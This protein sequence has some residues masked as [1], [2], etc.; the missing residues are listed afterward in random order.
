MKRI[1]SFAAAAMLLWAGVFAFAEGGQGTEGTAPAQETETVEEVKPP[2]DTGYAEQTAAPDGAELTPQTE[3]AQHT[4]TAQS[5]QPPENAEA[6]SPAPESVPESTP[7]S[8]AESVPESA[9]E[10]TE[11]K[12]N[13][14]DLLGKSSI[15]Y[16]ADL[17]EYYLSE[18]T[19]AA[20]AGDVEA[21]REA[22]ANRDHII[23]TNGMDC[24]KIAFDDLYLLAKLI[25]AEAGSDWLTEDFRLCMGEVVLNRVASPEF[26][27]T[28]YDVAYQPGQYSSVT[29]A[30]FANLIPGEGFVDIALRLLQGERQMVESVVYQSSYVQGEIFAV[31]EDWRLGTI[32]F[33][34]SKNQELYPVY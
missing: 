10:S 14:F 23:D 4:D 33:C 19:A 31:Y 26:P 8:A 28:L 5:G 11:S 7:E 22:C 29:T 18:M 17:A 32:Y 3:P 13:I 9:P 27:N 25:N 34:I 21:G 24:A 30:A 2:E 1:I 6:G 15:S 12:G 20:I 16:E